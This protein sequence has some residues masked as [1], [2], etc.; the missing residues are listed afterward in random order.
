M[1]NLNKC[2]FEANLTFERVVMFI[3]SDDFKCEWCFLILG[4][5]SGIRYINIV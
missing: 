5:I 2:L 1:I 3:Q 4:E